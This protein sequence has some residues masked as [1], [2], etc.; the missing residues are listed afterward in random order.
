MQVKK[1]PL[2]FQN[3]DQVL[4]TTYHPSRGKNWKNIR[5]SCTSK[6]ELKVEFY[7]SSPKGSP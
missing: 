6:N 4:N 5:K 7:G 1:K 3:I 2:V